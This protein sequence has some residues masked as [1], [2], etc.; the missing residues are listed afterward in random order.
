MKHHNTTIFATAVAPLMFLA[1][2]PSLFSFSRPTDIINLQD[3][4]NNLSCQ[5]NLLFLANQGFYNMLLLH[6]C[7]K[8]KQK[9][10][11]F[12]SNLDLTFNLS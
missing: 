5:R 9:N 10:Y 11:I 3:H 7:Q 8:K 12:S 2:Q 4:S 6:I 1:F